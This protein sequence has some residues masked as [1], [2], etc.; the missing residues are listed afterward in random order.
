MN[1]NARRIASDA[2]RAMG[3]DVSIGVVEKEGRTYTDDM[4]AAVRKIFEENERMFS[5]FRP[6]SELWRLNHALGVPQKVPE[7]FLDVL[8]YALAAHEQSEGLSDPRIGAILE[9][10]GYDRDFPRIAWHG[11]ENSACDFVPLT[12]PLADDVRIDAATQT[13]T[14]AHA[15]DLA[16]VVKGYTI[17]E[18]AHFLEGNGCA[19]FIVEAG[20]DLV[21]HGRDADD[22]VWT[23]GVE[24]VPVREC[25]LTVDN[26]AV[27]TS[28]ITRRRWTIK[29]R[30]YHH[31]INPKDPSRFSFDLRSVTVIHQD[32]LRA[33][34]F[35]KMLFLM[36]RKEGI[37]YATTHNLKALFFDSRGTSYVTP[38]FKKNIL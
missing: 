34:L 2:F 5:R 27:A 21:A 6:D 22:A 1:S 3:T 32:I 19:D 33:D 14:L 10:I 29:G 12:T 11:M 9:C 7:K 16:G 13:V 26:S 20:G 31:L 38:E 8:R 30:E 17:K 36:G 35:A 4:R 37:R 24:G 15:I 28:G 18:A 23:V 25:T